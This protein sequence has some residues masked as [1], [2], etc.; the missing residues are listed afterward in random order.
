MTE[1]FPACGGGKLAQFPERKCTPDGE[2]RVKAGHRFSKNAG[3]QQMDPGD[4]EIS[5]FEVG[6]Q[7]SALRDGPGLLQK[8]DRCGI[9]K[10]V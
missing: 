3:C 2:T 6:Y 10:M 1:L 5:P 9:S 4:P 7:N 8:L